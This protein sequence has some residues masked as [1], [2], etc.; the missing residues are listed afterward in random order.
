MKTDRE[1]ELDARQHEGVKMIKHTCAPA[2]IP[3]LGD[4]QAAVRN[5]QIAPQ[6]AS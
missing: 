6:T 1:S 3:R 2:R 5:H 4:H